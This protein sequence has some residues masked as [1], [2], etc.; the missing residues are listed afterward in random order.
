M[1]E[2]VF[3]YGTLTFPEVLCA[4][5]GRDIPSRPARLAGFA[6]FRLRGLSYPGVVAAPGAS[7]DGRA[8]E[9]V[10][11]AE[12]ARLDRFEGD[13]YVRR[14]VT[15]ETAPGEEALAWTWIL[16]PAA[17]RWIEERPWDREHFRRRDL[18]RFLEECRGGVA[19]RP[20]AGAEREG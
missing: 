2:R 11:A 1:A 7:T 6:R 20:R 17:E 3:V 13:A 19:P 16:A 4:V 15:V 12:L 18:A 9:D 5:T 14:R 10:S 8:L